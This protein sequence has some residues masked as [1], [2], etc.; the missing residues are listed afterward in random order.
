[1]SRDWKTRLKVL[2]AFSFVFAL[3][4][5]LSRAQAGAPA[6]PEAAPEG[7]VPAS[8]AQ[9]VITLRAE[10]GGTSSGVLYMLKG[11]APQTAVI[12]MHP[13][14][15]S[16]RNTFL[17]SLA[18]AGFASFG[19]ANRYVN[20]DT[21]GIHEKMLLD[22]AAGVRFLKSRG[23]KKI[24]LLGQSGGGSLMAFYQSQA[25]TTPPG[26]VK[27][28][29]AGDPPDL[30]QFELIPADGLLTIIPHLGEGKILETRI[31][32]SVINEGD[33]FS[34]DPSL[35]MYNPANGFCLPPETT[36]YSKEFVARYRAAQRARMERLDRWAR[37]LIAEQNQYR[38]LTQQPGFKSLPLQQQQAIERRADTERMM[39][40]SRTFADLRFM[41]LSIDPSD[42]VVGENSG[43]TPW[44]ATYALAPNPGFI[45]P[46]AFLSS[47]S[48]ISSNA[49]TL[50]N[51]PKVTV[52]TLI[53]QGTAQRQIY[54]SETRSIF[55]ASGAKDKKLVWVEGGDVSF[56]PSG[57]KAGKGDQ[58][59]QA[60]NA[61][62][63]WM[64]ERFPH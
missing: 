48:S 24:V 18:E 38:Q 42:R 20:N 3:S 44:R 25:T 30:N 29:P 8:L 50:K 57:P 46:R 2:A 45:S 26:R 55:E 33:P 43:T 51:I 21:D 39:T 59:Q 47:R 58:R 17:F 63:S 11:T 15:D 54:P 10:D 53:V 13:R 23:F 27:S 22:I 62:V 19:T 41:D 31:D 28:T 1:M 64:Q 36:T 37:S 4:T 61:V 9:E 56:R 40:L 6:R 35:D 32:P 7:A 14:S 49:V 52:P 60:T 34:I 5:G 12:A 16:G